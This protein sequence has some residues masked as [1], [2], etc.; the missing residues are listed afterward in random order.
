MFWKKKNI[1]PEKKEPTDAEILWDQQKLLK[2][3][4][5]EEVETLTK[6]Q[7]ILYELPEFYTFAR[8]LGVE[9]NPTFPLKS[10]KYL[11]FTDQM[12]DGMPTGKK[13]YIG[14]VNKSTDYA[15]WVSEKDSDK[16]GHVKR[17]Q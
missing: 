9:L 4:I 2:N 12:V 8:F 15:D 7:A 6:E 10:K 3:K 13:S 5:T 17:F 14:G 16:Y 11:M 1:Q